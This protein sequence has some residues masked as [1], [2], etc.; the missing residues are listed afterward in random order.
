M[1][2]LQDRLPAVQPKRRRKEPK[3]PKNK[4]ARIGLIRPTKK[5]REW[6]VGSQPS[7]LV[8]SN[9]P[10][11]R[12]TRPALGSGDEGG[13]RL[14]AA[15]QV[16]SQALAQALAQAPAQAPAE[17]ENEDEF[18]GFDFDESGDDPELEPQSNEMEREPEVESER[19]VE[20]LGP[21][22][23]QRIVDHATK[24]AQDLLARI[25]S[26]SEDIH[27]KQKLNEKLI[28]ILTTLTETSNDPDAE[29]FKTAYIELKAFEKKLKTATSQPDLLASRLEVVR[30][31]PRPG[32]GEIARGLG[33]AG[34]EVAHHGMPS[35]SSDEDDDASY[36][37]VLIDLVR[38]LA[39]SFN[40]RD[41]VAAAERMMRKPSLTSLAPLTSPRRRKQAIADLQRLDKRIKKLP[42]GSGLSVLV[43][44]AG[45]PTFGPEFSKYK[46]AHPLPK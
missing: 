23:S 4:N 12:K 16:Q 2:G 10:K 22:E 46:K 31:L 8:Y 6:H 7:R 30:N 37:A 25:S 34:R 5:T 18:A 3:K 9:I 29:P 36:K 24:I 17:A 26:G 32:G 43:E 33:A 45:K 19:L 35:D 27:E 21:E 14:S 11:Y 41:V 20:N 38:S 28:R 44:H 15:R 13:E 39:R 40:G 1:E 42:I